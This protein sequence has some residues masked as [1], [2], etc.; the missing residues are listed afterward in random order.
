MALRPVPSED[1]IAAEEAAKLQSL[2]E[3]DLVEDI[4]LEDDLVFPI[5]VGMSIRGVVRGYDTRDTT[6]MKV[7]CGACKSHQPHNRGFRV[8]LESGQFARIGHDCGEKQF[9]KGAWERALTDFIRREENA[10]YVA[11]IQPAVETISRVIPLIGEWHTYAKIIS[12]WKSNLQREL[13]D[14]YGQLAKQ[15]KDRSGALEKEKWGR[16]KFV[17][18][19]GS[20][21]TRAAVVITTVGNIPYP[22]MFFRIYTQRRLEWLKKRAAQCSNSI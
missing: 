4:D 19:A 18:T 10:H 5:P 9:G 12:I 7:R 17:D 3:A 22:Q 16:E 20:E 1:D 2:L 8:E 13:P 6:R 21:K 15:A 14:L 11:R